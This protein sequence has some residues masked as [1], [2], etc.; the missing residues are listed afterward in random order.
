MKYFRYPLIIICT[1]IIVI[2]SALTIINFSNINFSK[3]YITKLISEALNREIK[4]NGDINIKFI[5]PH[6][7]INN[8]ELENAAWKTSENQ[9]DLESMDVILDLDSLLSAEVKISQINLKGIKLDLHNDSKDRANWFFGKT[10]Q[11]D[12]DKSE[13]NKKPVVLPFHSNID[14]SLSDIT[15][16]YKD[17]I[18]KHD[19]SFFIE[20][21]KLRNKNN[22]SHIF[23][24]AVH[25]S[26]HLNL[27]IETELLKN[28]LVVKKLPI[29]ITGN[30]GNIEIELDTEIPLKEIDTEKLVIEFDIDFEN[31]STID[32][33]IKSGLPVIRNELG[34]IDIKGKLIKKEKK[35][36]LEMKSSKIGK[37]VFEGDIEYVADA[38]RPKIKA[39]MEF[40]KL[41]LLFLNK[42]SNKKQVKTEPIE[43]TERDVLFSETKLDLNFLNKVDTDLNIKIEDIDHK[44]LEF[45]TLDLIASLKNGLLI[46]KKLHIV[47]NRDEEIDLKLR[48]DTKNDNKVDLLFITENLK[49]GEN[50]V[51]SEYITGANTNLKVNL[52][53]KGDSVKN[54]MANLNGQVVVKVGEGTV[55]K[56][57]LKFIGSNI[58]MDLVDAVNPVSDSSETSSL[59]CAVVR[60]DIKDGVATANKGVVMQTD[61]IQVISSGMIDLKNETLEFGIKP[62][63]REGIELNLNS[64]ASMVKI[65]GS[66]KTPTISMSV[67]D[68]A[69]VYSYFAT[70][71]VTFLAKSLFDTATRDGNPCKTALLGPDE[72]N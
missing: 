60:L 53:G 20:E 17:E 4:F 24:N 2:I 15:V 8:V 35:I 61:K 48:L 65:D 36:T 31:F 67:K 33:F 18:I 9:I 62:Q 51:L 3:P 25:N 30:Y 40:E 55:D 14:I 57:L 63:A 5:P 71:G 37:S 10:T 45:E 39:A 28:I 42:D 32:K 44:Q 43:K 6:I 12:D 64:L 27:D 38:V 72:V 7:T 70:G 16:I 52:Q 19:H 29:M 66:I 47:N 58:L 13:K 22:K 49:L 21:L 1:L 59:E 56:D 69:V 46:I 68:T 41:D 23:I 54:M 34:R 11:S 50:D 26:E